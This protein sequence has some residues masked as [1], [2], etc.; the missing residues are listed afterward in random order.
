MTAARALSSSAANASSIRRS[1]ALVQAAGFSRPQSVRVTT[2]AWRSA[3]PM[4]RATSPE[5]II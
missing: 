5:V 3:E 2:E 1:W 4:S